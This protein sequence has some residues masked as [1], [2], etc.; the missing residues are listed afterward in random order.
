MLTVASRSETAAVGFIWRVARAVAA[1]L[2]R[3]DEAHA[4]RCRLAALPGEVLRD[5]GI[6]PCDAVGEA[7]WQPEL[8]FFMQDGFGERGR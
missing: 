6:A 8:P 3:V 2:G 5:S 1:R 7:T 4:A